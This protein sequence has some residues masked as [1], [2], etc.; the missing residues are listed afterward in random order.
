MMSS[1]HVTT[2]IADATVRGVDH[3]NLTDLF[4]SYKYCGVIY[5]VYLL[6]VKCS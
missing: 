6:V 2:L 4:T 3:F 5:V 1:H